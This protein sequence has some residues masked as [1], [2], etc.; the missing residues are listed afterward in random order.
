MKRNFLIS[1]F[2]LC[3]LSI[4][5][6]AQENVSRIYSATLHEVNGYAPSFVLSDN[7]FEPTFLGAIDVKDATVTMPCGANCNGIY[8]GFLAREGVPYKLVTVD[9]TAA[10]TTDVV[11]FGSDYPAFFDMAYNYHTGKVYAALNDAD[12]N[13]VLYEMNVGDGTYQKV[14]DLGVK[15][16]AIDFSF[17]GTLYALTT[18]EHNTGDGYMVNALT[19]ASYDSDFTLKESKLV[20]DDWSPY[21]GVYENDTYIAFSM[22]FDYLSGVLYY[23]QTNSL[24]QYAYTLDVKEGKR[25]SGS[26]ML[27]SDPTY[28]KN[29]DALSLYIPFIAPDGG[30]NSAAPV[31]GL[32]AAADAG[33]AL[34]ATLTWKNPTVNFVDEP[35]TELYSIRIYRESVS[36]E[37][38]LTEIMENVAVG[39]EMSWT[40]EKASQGN[41]TYVLVPCRVAGEKGIAVT[42]SVFAGF[43]VPGNVE[44]VILEKV[45]EGIKVSWQ[46]PTTTR[47][48]GVLD[49]STLKYTVVRMPDELPVKTDFTETSFVDTNPLPGWQDY[50]YMITAITAAGE[51]EPFNGWA[52][53]AGPAITAP[54][55]TTFDNE[56]ANGLWKSYNENNDGF[57]GYFDSYSGRFSISAVYYDEDAFKNLNTWIISPTIKLTPGQYKITVESYIDKADFANSFDIVYGTDQT[58]EAQT[59][60][61][62]SF[63]YSSTTDAQTDLAET[64]V[65]IT[66]DGGYNFSV[67]MTAAKIFQD[68]ER[69]ALGIGFFKIEYVG[70]LPPP[71]EDFKV[72]GTVVDD[73]ESAVQGAKV[74]VTHDGKTFEAET[75]ATGEFTVDVTGIQDAYDVTVEKKGYNAVAKQFAY[76]GENVDLGRI[77]L[78]PAEEDFKVTGTVVDDKEGLAVQGAKVTVTHG[79]KTFEAE[80]GATGEFTVDVT[81]IQDAYDVT[82]E[83]EGYNAV[84]KQFAYAGENVDLGR[85]VLT[86]AEEDFKVTGTVVDD[87]EGL[88]VQ[89]AKVT[90]THGDKTFEAETG[91][92]GEFTVDVTGIRDA[93]ELTVEKEGFHAMAQEFT[94]AGTDVDLGRVVLTVLSGIN[95]IIYDADGNAEIKIYD[96]SGRLVKTMTISKGESLDIQRGVYIINGVKHVVE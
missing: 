24:Q 84:A 66:A 42:I 86:P 82:V 44:S 81:G 65:N 91:A 25:L 33:G 85:I 63:S 45:P 48:G 4:T 10:K 74:T 23:T 61:L 50:S 14:A 96:L 27:G 68:Y 62:G 47:N 17:D 95:N 35:L 2:C 3:W 28:T 9:W 13:T 83:K 57:E 39:G 18:Q 76:A 22:E 19:L 52:I 94:Y 59:N 37:N 72:T 30:G 32:Q 60:N 58:V 78:T 6:V 54:Y 26:I 92:T 7:S 36:D 51:S 29:F 15:A 40:D 53:Y 64:L 43:D 56:K 12:G 55:E 88:A 90:V 69:C 75:S 5:G 38:L 89:G 20:F 1:L 87:K 70:E 80:T 11:S 21:V 93:Y 79:D 49:E 46:K 16:R 34:K 8:Y 73:K 71:E 77:V 67:H 41:N 31:T